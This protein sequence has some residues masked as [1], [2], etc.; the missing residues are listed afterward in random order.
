MLW[1][2]RLLCGLHQ[3]VH[4]RRA[5]CGA[6]DPDPDGVTNHVVADPCANASSVGHPDHGSNGYSHC[7]SNGRANCHS[8][9]VRAVKFTIADADNIVPFQNTVADPDGHANYVTDHIGAVGHPD[10]FC[11]D[12]VTYS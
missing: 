2:R 8:N 1:I 11:P 5:N 7:S 6:A 9:V 10:G 12:S 3:S 4:H